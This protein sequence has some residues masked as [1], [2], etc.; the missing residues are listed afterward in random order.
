MG[1]RMFVL[2]FTCHNTFE[3]F[4]VVEVPLLLPSADDSDDIPES[5]PNDD[6]TPLV[7]LQLPVAAAPFFTI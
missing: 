1:T 7:S 4:A 3:S 6:V 5:S 2:K